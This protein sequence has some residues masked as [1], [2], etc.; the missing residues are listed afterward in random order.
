MIIRVE[1]VA[2]W[3][4]FHQLEAQI[5]QEVWGTGEE[6]CTLLFNELCSS[7]GP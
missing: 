2:G 3:N 6:V 4:G 5:V 1:G 7:K